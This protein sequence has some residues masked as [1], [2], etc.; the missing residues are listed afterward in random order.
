ML[1]AMFVAGKPDHRA[2]AAAGA[3][4]SRQSRLFYVV[5]RIAG[6]RF[7]VDTGAEVS[8]LPVTPAEKRRLSQTTPLRA[9]NSSSIPTYGQRSLTIDLGLRRTFR[10]VY[11][12]AD[13]RM[14]ILGAD[15]LSHFNL[16]VNVHS[17]RLVDATTRLSVN[18]IASSYVISEV[19]PAPPSSTFEDLLAEFPELTRTNSLDQ[20]VRHSVT[21]HIVTTGPPTFARPRR[22]TGERL[23]I[24]RREF[25]HMLQLGIVRPSASN[26]SSPLHLVP[27]AIAGDWR[28]CGDYRALNAH[29]VPDRYPLPHIQDFTTNLAGKS[30]FT[31]I[32]L[33]KAYHQIPVE[34][35]DV[36]KTAITTPFGLFEYVR[37]PFGLRNAAQTFQRFINEVTRGLDFVFAY[38]D[39]LLVASSS[40]EEHEEH[41]RLLFDRLR[42]YGLVVN[43]GKC[44]F[45]VPTI[46]FLG[47]HITPDG[48]TPLDDKVQAVRDFPQPTSLRKLREFLGLLNFHRRFIPDCARI[49]QPLTDLL[50]TK[51]GPNSPVEWSDAAASAFSLAKKALVDATVLV[52]PRAEAPLRLMTD[53]SSVA[54]GAVLQQYIGGDWHPLAFFSQKMKPAETRYSTFGRELL[55]IF[56][57]VKHF[58][59]ILEGNTFHVLTDH[60]PLTFAFIG[61]HT[62]YSAREIRHLGFISEFTVDIRHVQGSDNSASDALSRVAALSPLPVTVDFQAMAEAQREDPDLLAERQKESSLQLNDIPLPLGSSTITCDVSTGNARPFVPL[63]FRKAVFDALHNPHHPGIRNTQRLVTT[64]YVWPSI[65]AD[66]RRWSRGCLHCQRSKVTRHNITPLV[67]FPLPEARFDHI[68]LDLVGPLPPC[69]GFTYILTCV[70]RYTRWP[71]AIPISNITAETV[72]E[73][74]VMHWISRYGCPSTITTDRG[75]Q[76]ESA[77]FTALTQLLGA[78]HIHTT[79]YHP[80]A[81]G[82]VE[83]LHRQLKAALTAQDDRTHWL[84]HLP[85]V[86][87][88]IRCAFKPDLQCTSAELVYGTAPRLPGEF[89]T[90]LNEKALPSPCA[91]MNRLREAFHQLQPTPPRNP[92]SRKVFMSQDLETCTHAF[93]RRDLVKRTLTPAYDGP[94]KVSARAAKTMT[95]DVKGKQEVITIDRIKPAYLDLPP[96]ASS[97]TSSP[98]HTG[99]GPLLQRKVRTVTWAL[100]QL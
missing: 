5:D 45:G 14:A 40:T 26:W 43:S 28:P 90:P 9:V 77:L 94:F 47:H 79:A 1:P 73:N 100:P 85:L 63:S 52:H 49:L 29:T 24:A 18:G 22:L 38:L 6:H 41:L 7:L 83:R 84:Q 62:N 13:I 76:F 89:F 69:Q 12:V 91:Y 51:K 80:S 19:R 54:V 46:D 96:A 82:M 98:S 32:D 2:L 53:A 60:K 16:A 64:R 8:V 87:L 35:S 33:V 67:R 50:R 17:R 78:R 27:K 86:L 65:N 95:L 31:R 37:M 15:F 3:P 66:V 70:D 57:S 97:V 99:P 48:I 11:I 42:S 4:G 30:V 36:A 74:F 20:P 34:P 25:D 75:R 56:L 71:E 81:N 10:W 88:G 59:H 39:D 23:N 21:H 58:R 55:A 72:A 92:A 44:V 68:H 93:V 61:N